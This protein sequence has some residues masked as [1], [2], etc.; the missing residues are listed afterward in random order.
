MIYSPS[1]N[2]KESAATRGGD[3]EEETS[4]ATV[5]FPLLREGPIFVYSRKERYDTTTAASKASNPT[6]LVN[7]PFHSLPDSRPLIHFFYNFNSF[8]FVHRLTRSPE[9][10]PS[11]YFTSFLC[12][13]VPLARL[14]FEGVVS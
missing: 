1:Q 8:Y 13:C 12:S 10:N 9:S 14:C 6:F 4:K 2:E 11:N 7:T 5:L 3:N